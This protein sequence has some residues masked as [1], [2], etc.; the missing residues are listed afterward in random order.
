MTFFI[1]S[2]F[3][4]MK[5]I[6]LLFLAASALL[7]QQAPFGSP[8]CAGESAGR[9]FFFLCH[10][11]SAKVPLWAG[12]VLTRRQLEQP[13][14]S[15]AR[16][17]FRRDDALHSPG[18]TN[19]DYRH[20]GFSRGH[21]VPAAD[22]RFSDEAYRSTFI[23]SNAIPQKQSVNSGRWAAAEA[24][25]RKLVRDA[26]RV[27]V[28]AGPLF[29]GELQRIGAGR[30]AVPSHTFKVV[31]AV[32]GSR[33]AMYA[34]IVPNQDGVTDSL[35]EL[36]VPVDE[37]EQRTG[38]DFF[39]EL[40]DSVERQLESRRGFLRTVTSHSPSVSQSVGS[41]SESSANRK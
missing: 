6:T 35:D 26:D 16:P 39:S 3:L 28:F 21:L 19:R 10:S 17:H 31:L 9:T 20:S 41:V 23:L 2:I 18:A 40:E 34:L 15:S 14:R 12:Y 33:H 22:F 30:V 36:A 29:E 27:H 1:L 37:V 32:R 24:A 38:L 8:A 11:P 4:V 13:V 7:A 5:P 25:V